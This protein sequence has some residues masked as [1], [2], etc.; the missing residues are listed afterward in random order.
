VHSTFYFHSI[1]SILIR[2]L[3]YVI[4]RHDVT[5]VAGPLHL[6]LHTYIPPAHCSLLHRYIVDIF[7]DTLLLLHSFIVVPHCCYSFIWYILHSIDSF[8]DTL[9]DSSFVDL[10]LPSTF[11]VTFDY[12]YIGVHSYIPL[13]ST[14]AFHSVGIPFPFD[15]T[16]HCW[17]FCSPSFT[18][19]SHSYSMETFSMPT[20]LLH[21]MMPPSSFIVVTCSDILESDITSFVDTLLLFYSGGADGN[22]TSFH[23]IHLH[24]FIYSFCWWCCYILMEVHCTHFIHCSFH[25]CYSIPVV[26]IIRYSDDIPHLLHWWFIIRLILFVAL[27]HLFIAFLFPTFWRLPRPILIWWKFLDTFFISTFILTDHYSLKWFDYSYDIYHYPFITLMMPWVP[28]IVHLLLIVVVVM[29]WL[30]WYIHDCDPILF[31]H[32]IIVVD[33]LHY[34]PY[35]FVVDLIDYLLIVPLHS[36][37]LPSTLLMS[38]DADLFWWKWHSFVYSFVIL[39]TFP[40]VIL[41]YI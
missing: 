38:H 22:F 26:D 34:P 14:F 16:I 10:I 9:F 37:P 6:C 8:V 20:F 24:S 1:H 28:Y 17:Y 29:I 3:F 25:C 39:V 27:F 23:L 32:S 19:Y 35:S 21:L 33:C 41:L 2:C 11:V 5:F 18:R 12:R 31:I 7:F 13:R 4:L 40:R 30:C 15:V 36:C